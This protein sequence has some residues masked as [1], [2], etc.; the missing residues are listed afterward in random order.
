MATN[1]GLVTLVLTHFFLLLS[2]T[3]AFNIIFFNRIDKRNDKNQNRFIIITAIAYGYMQ[4]IL[5]IS[6]ERFLY[7]VCKSMT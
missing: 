7:L 3:I 1:I 2:C 5:K 6:Y 4:I